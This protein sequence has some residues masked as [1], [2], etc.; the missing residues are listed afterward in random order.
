[1]KHS[2]SHKLKK[3]T[4]ALMVALSPSVFAYDL[5]INNGRVMDPESGFDKIAN[6]AIE[7]G[8]IVAISTEK[9]TADE[10]IDATGL[11]VSPGFIDTHSHISNMPFGQKI[12]LRTGV[13]TPLA[14]EVGAYPINAWYDSFEGQ[15][16]TNFG[17]SVSAAGVRTKVLN[18]NYETR[19]GT[20]IQDLF[21]AQETKASH[22]DFVAT[23]AIANDEQIEQISTMIEEEL[24]QGGLGIGV[25]VGY[26]SEA[27]T[28]V[29]TSDWQRLAGKYNVS[30][31][32]HG[33]FSSQLPPTSGMLSI[34]EMMANVAI[35]GGGLLVQHM[36]QQT[37]DRTPQAL[38]MIDKANERGFNVKAEIYPYNF[39][40][41]IVAADYLV[42]DNYEDKM[43]RTYSDI[44]E[45]ETMEPLTKERYEH[46]MKTNPGASV[47]FYAATNNDLN[48]ALT[49][50]S[51]TIASDAFP[52][53]DQDGQMVYDWDT[54]YEN[55]QGHPRAAGTQSKVLR[56]V[57]EEN[58][59]P[60]MLAIS[61]MSYMPAKFLE[62]NGVEQMA[63]KGRIQTGA[64]ADI[65]IFNPET[66]TDNSTLKDPGLP[67]TGIPYV[68]VDG[69]VVVK[70]SK[71][72]KDVFPGQ[73]I[74]GEVKTDKK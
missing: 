48:K 23:K 18:E 30:T 1:M 66:V 59:M 19:T 45:M 37:L 58:I 56:L 7:N 32:L 5:V 46:L 70:E 44:I 9:M 6:V 25:P 71:V 15:S 8:K 13:T 74:R 38:E 73:P 40:A 41:T 47:M 51:A 28:F 16:Q 4:L 55:L 64:D 24:Q 49:H 21:H 65:T 27:T 36:H 69:T 14:L 54:P 33:R 42:P 68:I 2:I 20:M 57:R 62:D 53:M 12:Q 35:Y 26:M 52:L 22:V 63:K 29:E 3:T 60:L 72:L 10:V 61:K 50:P 31:Y 43:G 34:E 39:G 67:A 17:A 11:V